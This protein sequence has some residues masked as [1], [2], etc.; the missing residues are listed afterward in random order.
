[1]SLPS[2]HRFDEFYGIP[3]DTSWDAA[4]GVA[5]VE[6]TKSLPLPE[7][8]LV[9][10]GPWIMAQTVGHPMERVKPFNADVRAEI[11]N[12]LTAKSIDFIKR[13]HAA[14]K[15]FFL[16]L[17]FSMGHAPTYPSKEFAGRSR[18]RQ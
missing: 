18:I 1:V 5:L 8:T 14:G 2:A 17:P 6:Q 11:D 10:K 16:Y 7:K 9:D 12:E 3:P 13:Q 15:P 4:V